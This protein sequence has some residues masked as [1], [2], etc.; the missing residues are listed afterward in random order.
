MK[1][2][3]NYHWNR[4]VKK[5]VIGTFIINEHI[6]LDE[7]KLFSPIHAPCFIARKNETKRATGQEFFTEHANLA[8]HSTFYVLACG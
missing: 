3:Q 4:K 8:S 2:N 7:I 1:W 5:K 6:V